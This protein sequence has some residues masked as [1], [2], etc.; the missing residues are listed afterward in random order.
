[1]IKSGGTMMPDFYGDHMA[2]HILLL[3]MHSHGVCWCPVAP[4]KQG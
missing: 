2:V 3:G 4:G 1:M